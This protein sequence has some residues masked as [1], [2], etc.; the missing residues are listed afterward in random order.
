MKLH[1]GELHNL[2]LS[3]NIIRQV[4]SRRMRWA[5]HVARMGEERTSTRFWWESPKERD[6]SEDQGMDGIRMDLSEIG[7]RGVWS[8]FSWLRIRAGD[9]LF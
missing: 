9:G 4:K 7:W 8:G 5:G 1:R 2:Y 3:S 6:H